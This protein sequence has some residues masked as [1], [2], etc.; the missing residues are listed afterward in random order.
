M[1]KTLLSIC[2]LLV[3]AGTAFAINANTVEIV[4]NGTTATVNVASNIASYVSVGSGTSSHVRIVQDSLFAG[5]D[6]TVDNED[7]EIIYVLSGTSTDGEFFLEGSFKATVEL[8]GLTL[9][10]PG[11][12]A[13]NLQDGKRISMSVKNGTTNTLTDGANEDYNGCIHC[14]GHLKLKGKGTLNVAGKSR[15][16]IYSKE[17]L[18]VKNLTLNVTGAVKDGIHCKEY[19]LVESGTLSVSGVQDDAI[20]VELSGTT[21]T[22]TTA[23]HE[24]EDS[25]NFY[26]TGGTL[27]IASGYQGKAVKADGTISMTGGTR[28]F[29][30][31]STE[32]YAGVQGIVLSEQAGTSA[33]FDLQGR[34]ATPHAKGLVLLRQGGKTI[35]TIR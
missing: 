13:I 29:D 21:S 16:G 9:T 17:Y 11:G 32:E 25:G 22:G 31:T 30:T 3:W 4:F 24:D 6:K 23:S 20:Q 33:V 27:T 8:R 12:P 10:N 34:R 2:A 26:M 1:K 19:M 7:G 18:E 15:H 14:K 35:K 5:V 28:N